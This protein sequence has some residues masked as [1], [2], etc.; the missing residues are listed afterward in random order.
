ME[1]PM[2]EWHDLSSYDVERP[3]AT[4]I[5]AVAD[6]LETDASDILSEMGYISAEAA[7]MQGEALPV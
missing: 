2:M 4:F 6:L 1:T 3:S 5:Q 7:A